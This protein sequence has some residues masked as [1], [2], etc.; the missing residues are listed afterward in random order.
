MKTR[1]ALPAPFRTSTSC[2]LPA[3]PGR[4]KLPD[5]EE[6]ARATAGT[7]RRTR[8]AVPAVARATSSV[9][10]NFLRLGFAGREQEVEVRKGA[11]SASLVFIGDTTYRVEK[12]RE[13][14]VT[15]NGVP[16][17]VEVREIRDDSAVVMV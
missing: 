13:N 11:G 4:R 10:G 6:V 3:K 17:S 2:S 8:R 12:S 14:L 1:E 16:H 15:V 7:A 5:T 9:S